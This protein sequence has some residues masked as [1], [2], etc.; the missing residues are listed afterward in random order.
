MKRIKSPKSCSWLAEKWY[1]HGVKKVKKLKKEW[2]V[3]NWLDA[4]LAVGVPVALQHHL[5]HYLSNP[6]LP[7]HET[8][9][10]LVQVLCQGQNKNEKRN[11]KWHKYSHFGV[12]NVSPSTSKR[13]KSSSSAMAIK[14]SNFKN[15][16]NFLQF[17]GYILLQI[18]T[19]LK[20]RSSYFS[21]MGLS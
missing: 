3:Y 20:S 13:A 4:L 14:R 1:F 18:P 16:S 17:C 8:I 6:K 7:L 9:W 5:L 10:W 2:C 21:K 12:L 19:F 15:G 11:T